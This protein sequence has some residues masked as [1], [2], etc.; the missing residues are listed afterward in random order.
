MP[1]EG[2]SRGIVKQILQYSTLGIEMGLSVAIGVGIGYYM[3]R[4]LGTE[5]WFFILFLFFGIAAGFR[6]L[7]R[8]LKRMQREE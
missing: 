6:N 1:P 2:R 7:Y 4:W 3:D 5:P 8:A